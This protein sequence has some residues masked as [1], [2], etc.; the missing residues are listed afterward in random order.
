MAEKV[1]D[2]LW[3]REKKEEGKQESKNRWETVGVL[4]ENGDKKTVKMNV[5]PVG[6]WDGYLTVKE[7]EKKTA[8]EPKK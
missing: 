6:E 8:A 5:M 4:I 2:L 7:R 1:Y 3:L